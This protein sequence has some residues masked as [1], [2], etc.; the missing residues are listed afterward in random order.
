MLSK[1]DRREWAVLGLI[2]L[3]WALLVAPLVHRETHAHGTA[4]SH[5]P[6][7]PLKHG[8]GSLEHQ[9][10]AFFDAPSLVEPTPVFLALNL[11]QH[12]APDSVD[13]PQLRRVEQSQAP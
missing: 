1:N 6:N 4:H 12:H 3:G 9:A 5:G 13:A 8:D 7:S 10:L 2:A 11:T